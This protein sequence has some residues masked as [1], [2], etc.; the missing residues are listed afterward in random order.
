MDGGVGTTEPLQLGASADRIQFLGGQGFPGLGARLRL[1]KRH[2]SRPQ[3]V[4]SRGLA[5]GV[6]SWPRIETD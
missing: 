6:K 5:R 1:V 4:G 3:R 2:G